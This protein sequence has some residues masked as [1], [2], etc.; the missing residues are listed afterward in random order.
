MPSAIISTD[1]STRHMTGDIARLVVAPRKLGTRGSDLAVG[2][3]KIPRA[4]DD[5]PQTAF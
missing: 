1:D 5:L 2:P 3:R 4:I